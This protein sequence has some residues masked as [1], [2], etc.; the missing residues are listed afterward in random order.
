MAEM[1]KSMAAHREN[2]GEEIGG[3]ERKVKQCQRSKSEN[4]GSGRRQKKRQ[5]GGEKRSA[6][7]DKA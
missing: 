4:G 2:G 5:S 3:I 7:A 6:K 1:A